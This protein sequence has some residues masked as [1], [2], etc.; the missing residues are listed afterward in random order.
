M[1]P[2]VVTVAGTWG[3]GYGRNGD[4]WRP[5]SAF[6]S[7]LAEA[8]V[9]LVDGEDPFAWSTGIDGIDGQNL[10]W[11]TAG[12]ALKWYCEAKVRRDRVSVVAHSHGGQVV[13]YAAAAGARFETVITVA[14]PVREDLDLQYQALRR[15]SRRWIHIYTD[16]TL[17]VAWQLL[18]SLG[19]ANLGRRHIRRMPLADDNIYIPGESHGDLV[20]KA[21][22]WRPE[23]R[24]MGWRDLLRVVPL[25]VPPATSGRPGLDPQNIPET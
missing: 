6:V 5:G 11:Q 25:S 19:L 4:W 22:L 14:S 16:E 7:M 8:G 10:T 13:A 12:R 21:D 17:G 18:G 24:G 3:A 1:T 2:R 9:S 23:P 15:Q 20:G